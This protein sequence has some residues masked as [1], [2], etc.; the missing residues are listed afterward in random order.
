[1]RARHHRRR[2]SHRRQHHHRT[3]LENETDHEKIIEQAHRTIIL[4]DMEASQLVAHHEARV[5]VG[6]DERQLM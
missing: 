1:M 6:A 2:H 4:L 5:I 3:S